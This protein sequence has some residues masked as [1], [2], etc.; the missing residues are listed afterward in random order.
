MDKT[1]YLCLAHMSE[2]GI[3][4]KYV[5]E[6]FETNWVVPL[7]PNVNAFEEDLKRFVGEGK[8]VVA[9]SAGTAAVHLALLACGVGQGDEVIVQ[10]FTFCAS[11]HPVTYLGAVPVFVDSEKETWNMSPEL[12]EEAIKDRIAKTGKKPKAIVPVALYGM[13]YDCT[14]I[15]EIADR[16]AIPVVEDA[17]E[18]FGSRF[19]GQ[20]LGTFGKFGVLSF[21]GNKM[22]T[23]SGGGALICKDAESKNQIM[24]YATQAREAY[25]YYQ[26]EAIGYNYRMSNICAGIGRGQMTVADKH[27]AHHRH[28]QALY[29]ELL[30][31]VE[32]VLLHEAPSA[33]YDSNFWLCTITLDS[34]LRIKG[35]ENAYKDVVRTAVGGAAGVIHAVDCAT[36][37][38]QPNENVEALRAFMLGKKIEARP[39]W[40]PM[41]KQPVYKDAPAYI[42]GVSEA[43]FK[44]GMCLP[45]GPWVT[46]EDVYYIVE[47][48]KEAIVK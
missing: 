28:V 48:I 46:D 29:K 12:L 33:D 36:T 27:I 34:S 38:C 6:A 47:C 32:G 42:N 3:E 30:K 11:S 37:D 18:G 19:K 16:Y 44:I 13:P 8:E 24:W 22:I 9:L 40:K 45:A 4:Q 23:T 10:S 1:I 20:V 2:E 14:R 39:V 35:Q 26:H 17:A 5:K 25:P 43:I 7:G 41:H 15:M 21:N 31:D